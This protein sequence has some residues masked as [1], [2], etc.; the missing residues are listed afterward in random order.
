MAECNKVLCCGCAAREHQCQHRIIAFCD[1][2]NEEHKCH[3]K[4]NCSESTIAGTMVRWYESADLAATSTSYI[5]TYKISAKTKV[6]IINQENFDVARLLRRGTNEDRD[7]MERVFRGYGFDVTCVND[8][9][10]AELEKVMESLVADMINYGQLI[11][12]IMTHG[13]QS[14]YDKKDY[15]MAR[16]KKYPIDKLWNYLSGPEF[17]GKPKFFFIQACR[18][19]KKDKR[20]KKQNSYNFPNDTLLLWSSGDGLPSKRESTIVN[21]QRC[22]YGSYFIQVLGRCLEHYIDIRID[23]EDVFR[24]VMEFMSYNSREEKRDEQVPTINSNLSQCVVW[25]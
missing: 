23:I 8:K 22:W 5:E 10:L 1:K 21:G 24:K 15:L 3:D 20:K 6:L 14:S 16:D 4:H 11:I 9:T 17:N 25:K 18:R 13:A 19:M 2:C 7:L 12:V